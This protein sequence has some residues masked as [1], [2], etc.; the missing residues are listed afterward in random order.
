MEIYRMYFVLKN[1]FKIKLSK[2]IIIPLNMKESVQNT[3]IVY[4]RA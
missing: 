3:L 1:I 4:K 2:F